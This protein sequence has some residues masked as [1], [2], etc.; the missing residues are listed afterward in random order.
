MNKILSLYILVGIFLPVF[1]FASSSVG[2]IDSVY[3]YA[4][5]EN[6]GRLNFGC[7][8]CIVSISDSGLTGY[9]WSDNFGRIKLNPATGGV[10]NNGQGVLSGYAWAENLGRINFSGVVI[11]SF[12]VFTG[13]ATG[14]NI[15]RINFN[16]TG[17]TV[18]TDWRPQSVRSGVALPPGAYN[19]PAAPGGGFSILI[20]NGDTYTSNRTVTLQLSGGV[21]AKKMAISNSP[22]FEGVGQ[23]DYQSIK[24]WELAPGNGLKTVY[25]KFYTKYGQPSD[26]AQR[27]ITLS[28]KTQVLTP[29]SLQGN[30]DQPNLQPETKQKPKQNLLQNVQ[31]RAQDAANKVVNVCKLGLQKTKSVFMFFI[32]A[33]KTWWGNALQSIK[34]RR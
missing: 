16:C 32:D 1:V 9:V 13:M 34:T 19:P 23:E 3:K 6:A 10:T 11:N 7:D 5:A 33:V 8:G 21:D 25:V 12:G 31:S 4:W 20:N 17:C 29:A 18:K 24:I 22:D 15:G 27:S 28:S 30:Q 26:V 14:D 2:T